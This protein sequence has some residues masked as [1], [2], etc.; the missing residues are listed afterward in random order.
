[1]D[2]DQLRWQVIREPLEGIAEIKVKNSAKSVLYLSYFMYAAGIIVPIARAIE[3]K[4]GDL[5]MVFSFIGPAIA[6]SVVYPV[7]NSLEQQIRQ[8]KQNRTDE[9][10]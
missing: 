8:L 10:K 4:P 9:Q 2:M 5:S 7:L 6:L 3:G 1:M